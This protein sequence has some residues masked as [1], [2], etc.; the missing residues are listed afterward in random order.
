MDKI[1]LEAYFDAVQGGRNYMEDVI[2]VQLSN[3]DD[4]DVR[5]LL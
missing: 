4:P 5:L 3:A 1:K 2:S